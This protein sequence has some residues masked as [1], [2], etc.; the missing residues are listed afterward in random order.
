MMISKKYLKN[1][2]LLFMISLFFNSSHYI[3][4]TNAR[5]E[6]IGGIPLVILGASVTYSACNMIKFLFIEKMFF[7]NSDDLL[8]KK[9]FCLSRLLV[10]LGVTSTGAFLIKDGIIGIVQ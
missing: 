7:H 1:N 4:S 8:K 3:N 6:L 5:Y 2:Y 10:G 9:A